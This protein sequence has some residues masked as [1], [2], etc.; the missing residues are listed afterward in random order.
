IGLT[1]YEAIFTELAKRQRQGE[2]I[3]IVREQQS[4]ETTTRH[5][6]EMERSNVQVMLDG[7]GQYP[8]IIGRE[9]AKETVQRIS[10]QQ[11]I[12]LNDNQ[13]AVV[14]QVLTSRDQIIG[15]Q[16]GAGTGKTTALS[17]VRQAAE[18][19][20]YEV[21]GFAPTTRAAQQLSESGIQ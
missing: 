19:E 2:F 20:G 4:P 12:Q 6:L 8:P 11:P 16:G 1:T 14:E 3:G 13:R 17:A 21:R 9:R 7:R 5:M 15:L 10:E 18:S